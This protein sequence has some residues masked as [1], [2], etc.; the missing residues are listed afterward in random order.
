MAYR[1]VSDVD[2]R[3]PQDACA[4]VTAESGGAVAS[5]G[6]VSRVNGGWAVEC[7]SCDGNREAP[8]G[9]GRI[10]LQVKSVEGNVARVVGVNKYEFSVPAVQPIVYPSFP[11]ESI[12]L[13]AGMTISCSIKPGTES[14]ITDVLA[15][16]GP[17][18]DTAMER[19]EFEG[20]PDNTIGWTPGIATGKNFEK[21]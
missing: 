12:R 5:T 8:V 20:V 10:W 15:E 16:S 3:T 19:P 7:F 1:I 9:V 4:F 13:V 18:V 14:E 17:G 11:G 21:Q 2:A 6:K